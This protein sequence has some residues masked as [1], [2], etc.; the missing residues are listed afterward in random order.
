MIPTGIGMEKTVGDQEL[1]LLR[2]VAEHSPAT[3]G[4]VFTGFGE[5][6]GLARSTVETVLERLRKKGFLKRILTGKVYQY[7]PTTQPNEV[8]GGLVEQFVQR[9]LG[10][11][12]V[13]FVNYFSRQERLSK[14]EIAELERLVRKLE[15]EPGDK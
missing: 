10:G 2:F 1:S 9:T 11:S 7:E 6:N 8:M 4:E 13:P 12:L 3:A 5:P 15:P 14:E